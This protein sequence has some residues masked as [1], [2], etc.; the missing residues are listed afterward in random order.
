[1]TKNNVRHQARHLLALH[2]AI[3]PTAILFVA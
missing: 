3:F 1:M 2:G